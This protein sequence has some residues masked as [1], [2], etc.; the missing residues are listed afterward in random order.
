M[1]KITFSFKSLLVAC[2]L[3]IGSANAWATITETKIVDCDFNNGETLFTG[4]SRMTVSNDNNVKFTCAG[5]SQNGYSLATYDFSS[6][7][8]EDATAVKIEFDFWISSNNAA[9][10]RFFTVGQA[11][12]RTGFGK[13]SYSTA[14][15]M[16]A[17][18]LARN[19]S[20]NYFSI[21]GA[22]TTAAASA[23][24]VLGAWT[25][26]EINVD[27]I[28][29]T[30]SYKITSMDG[31]TTYYSGKDLA[32]VDASASNC[33]QLD[34]FDC[35]N[36]VVSYLDNLVITKYVD[37]SKAPTTYTVKYQ[38][39][40][41]TDLKDPV[42]YD[43][44]EGSVITAST[45]DMATFYSSDNN[46]KYVYASGN[47]S[48][49]ASATASENV[50][51][52]VFNEYEKVAYSVSAVCNDETLGP[53]AKGET[54]ADGS[55]KINWSKYQ[56]FNDKWYSCNT[57]V[58]PIT[59]SGNTNI[60]FSEADILYF[61][62][63]ESLNRSGGA[64]LTE[65]SDSYSKRTRLRLS[66]G[67]LYYTPTLAAGLYTL[68][69]NVENSNNSAS[70]VYVY[71]RS[72]DGTLS[73][74]LYTHSA[75]KGSSQISC[76]IEVPEGHSIAF[77]GNEG[78][79]NNNAR[80]D[81]M[82]LSA[83][84]VPVPVS[85]AGYASFSSEY[86]LDL[87]NIKGGKA[88]IVK[89]DAVS[90]DNIII[91][92]QTGKVAANTGLILKADGGAAGTITIPVAASGDAVSENKLV[93][94]TA[95]ATPV[96]HENYVLGVK[97]SQVGFCKLATD[98]TLDKGKAYLPGGFSSVKVLNF[99]IEGE[100]PTGVIYNV[101]GQVVDKNYKGIVIKNGKK[102]INK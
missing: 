3:L 57:Y 60:E 39:A 35:Q 16:F 51:T 12:M 83:G 22:S 76:L 88:Y 6:A 56:K 90:G 21:N 64:Y 81:Y 29:K 5:N 53:I 36:N 46:T 49:E 92:P 95:D 32:F 14:G 58:A 93:A 86:A 50:I 84:Y 41:G 24:N 43:T 47:T 27:I 23:T 102:Y 80:M 91:T 78:S 75:P 1:Q 11:N 7:M 33:T 66:K 15:S 20:A 26:A 34:F 82:T 10:R 40:S 38:N 69:I 59:K 44:Y 65:E 96:A 13:T 99:I 67:S 17:F 19:S 2:G 62:E 79:A 71:T 45:T 77:N 101:N 63:M 87:D 42:L 89:A 9:Y 31:N 98:V 28:S 100:T 52:L 48:T 68:D 54:Y 74:K 61:F 97:G 30:I 37:N 18:G 72:G 55:T 70:E 4:V 85:N 25:H 73:E 8:G 94:V